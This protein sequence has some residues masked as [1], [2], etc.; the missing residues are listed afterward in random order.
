VGVIFSTDF[1]ARN[2][3][4]VLSEIGTP[5]SENLGKF[6]GKMAK[7]LKIESVGAE[8]LYEG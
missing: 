5:V 1:C 7:E 2:A 3:I 6:G 8:V 4:G